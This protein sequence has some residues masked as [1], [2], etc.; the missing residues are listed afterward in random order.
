[1]ARAD[2]TPGLSWKTLLPEGMGLE[3]MPTL[4]LFL[5][6]IGDSVSSEDAESFL[7]AG[8]DSLVQACRGVILI[9]SGLDLRKAVNAGLEA[10]DMYWRF[11]ETS[12]GV[13][14]SSLGVPVRFCLG[15]GK[16]LLPSPSTWGAGLTAPPIK[17]ELG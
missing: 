6:F 8:E 11:L 9:I 5:R 2:R 7:L 15:L 14:H 10:G 4:L 13:L 17:W 12:S 16:E 3:V 1:M